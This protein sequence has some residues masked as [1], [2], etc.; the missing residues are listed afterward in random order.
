MI[1]FE[2]GLKQTRTVIIP[3]GSLEEH[4]Q[5][6]PLGTDTIQIYEIAKGVAQEYP[7]F[8]APPV[9]Y[10]LCR[11]T[12]DHP[13]TVTIK[14]QT[15]W[16]I[17]HDLLSSFYDQ[18]LRFFALVSGHAGKTHK[19]FILDAAEVFQEEHPESRILVATIID[20]ISAGAKDLLETPDD[21]HA[22]EF[23]TSL[24][25]LLRPDWVKGSSPAEYPTL[26]GLLLVRDK[27]RYWPGGVWGDPSK[28][29]SNKGK[30]LFDRLVKILLQ[31]IQ[32]LE[33][34]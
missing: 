10:G 11:S 24:M 5:H 29:S 14:G 28:A 33:S 16:Q 30:R 9:Y 27:R 6:L 31:E 22:G 17:T 15:L 4:G 20:L 25:A 21:S 8:V 19:A 13:G 23:E 1:E 32:K 34:I 2:E 3:F 26:P 7:L 12:K 18:G